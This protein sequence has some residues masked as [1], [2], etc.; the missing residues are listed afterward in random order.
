MAP[1]QEV[2]LITGV[3]SGLGTALA[4]AALAAGHHVIGTVRSRQRASEEVEAIELQGGK[5]LELD[6][7]DADACRRVLQEAEEVH[8]RVDHLINN[9][10][11][12]WLGAVEDYTYDAHPALLPSICYAT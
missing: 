4:V 12:S 2:A 5:C 7:T 10:G 9:A 6:V 1:Q 11:M 3:S 8:G